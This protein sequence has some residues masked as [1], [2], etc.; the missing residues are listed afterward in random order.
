MAI[1]D[2][3]SHTIAQLV[4][5]TGKTAVVTGGAQGIGKAI[6]R[7][8]AE[9]GASVVIGD[10]N[11]DGAQATA[12]ELAGTTGS[13][14][15]GTR[16]D[17]RDTASTDALAQKAVDELGGIDI[18]V[19]NAGVYPTTEFLAMSDAD[20]DDVVA[21][22]LRG[23]FTGSR[24]AARHMVERGQG[25]VI[26]NLSS[27]AGFRAFGPG[28]AHYTATKHAVRGLTMSLAVELGPQGIRALAIAPT[29]I[30]TEGIA[31][32]RASFEDVGLDTAQDALL[33]AHPLKRL[34]VPDD[35]ARV[36]LF[37]ASDL[38]LLMS[39]S[40]LLVDAGLMAL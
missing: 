23:T 19:N 33:E 4:D 13:D 10:I 3:S 37:C 31:A 28:L 17:V 18:W 7:R 32:T 27:I 6:S 8:L 15:R 1:A 34:G 38:S 26:I 22:N 21:I 16:V 24:A 20:W 30:V 39:G 5:L 2:V 25:G 11:A 14:L 35:I 9:A 12:R 40:T 36:A 29:L